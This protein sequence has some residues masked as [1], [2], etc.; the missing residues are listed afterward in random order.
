[1]EVNVRPILIAVALLF[2]CGQPQPHVSRVATLE[3]VQRCT[4]SGCDRIV[5]CN[6]GQWVSCSAGHRFQCP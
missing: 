6:T 4:H 5:I 3:H 2:S 1:M